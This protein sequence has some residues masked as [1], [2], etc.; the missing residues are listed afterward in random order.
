[1]VTELAKSICMTKVSVI[2]PTKNVEGYIGDLLSSI[3]H[4]DYS[5]E[6]ETIILDSSNDKT[7]EI[8]KRFPVEFIRIEEDNYNYGGTRNYG[9]RMANGKYLIFLS[10]DVVIKDPQW[11]TKLLTPFKDTMIA[12]VFGR[13]HPKKD[14][15]PMEEFFL[16]YFYPTK[17]DIREMDDQGKVQL[18]NLMF[19]SNA[20]S[21]IRK[22]IW[23]K[24]KLPEML[25][26]ED[27][28]WA[29]RVLFAGYK[30]A[31]TSES[32]VYHSHNYSLK[33][34]FHRFFD[35]G[36]TLP[37]VYRH[38][39]IEYPKSIF[40]IE[41]LKYLKAECQYI[42]KHGKVKRL[43]Y[44]M[45]Y[46]FMRFLGYFLGSNHKYMPLWLKVMLCN[47]KNHW[48]KYSDIIVDNDNIG[49]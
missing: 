2:L 15:S 6:I 28:E 27:H 4:Q 39:K 33:Q 49:D 21:A 1:M 41:G 40:I 35:T 11:L 16:Q 7:P 17:N 20:N 44:A 47:K 31:Y 29:K 9:A 24:I 43:P 37:Y 36:A 48:K 38:E 19:F 18:T 26:C 5:G 13:Q 32:V 30:I 14:A 34:V 42:V 25:M 8:A 12:G 10:A 22:D 45:L 23:K 3:Y 46:E